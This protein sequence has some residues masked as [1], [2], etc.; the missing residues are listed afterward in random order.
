[1]TK[2]KASIALKQLIDINIVQLE[3]IEWVERTEKAREGEI[4]VKKDIVS[5]KDLGNSV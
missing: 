5:S 1:M 3:T 2:A 4:E